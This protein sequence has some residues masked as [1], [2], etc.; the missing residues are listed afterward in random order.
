MRVVCIAAECEPWAKTG[1]LGDVVDALARAVGAAGRPAGRRAAAARAGGRKPHR[2][3]QSQVWMGT[4]ARHG[5]R[6]GRG[7]SARPRR[8]AGGRLPAAGTAAW[9]FRTERPRPLAVPDPLAESGTTEVTLVEFEDRGYRVRLIDHPPAFD[10]DGLLRR[11]RRRLRRQRLALRAAV[12]GRHRG[13]AR[14]RAAGR[15]AASPRLAGHAG[16]GAARRAHTRRIRSSLGP[17]SWS[18]STTSP[19]RAG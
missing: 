11:R 17:R 14:R 9:P 3:P 18:R 15:R 6:Q 13:P 16:G 2:V 7:R 5:R 10:R 12:P 19:T 4:G 8:A 1:G